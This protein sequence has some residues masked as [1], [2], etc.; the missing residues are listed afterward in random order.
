[1]QPSYIRLQ[2]IRTQLV[3]FAVKPA[4]CSI[5]TTIIF[6]LVEFKQGE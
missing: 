5:D 4:I 1:M 3:V 2:Q 6:V